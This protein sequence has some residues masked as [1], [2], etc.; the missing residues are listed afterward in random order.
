[1]RLKPMSKK[2]LRGD[3]YYTDLSPVI[4]C[5][6]NGI[7]PILIIQNNIGNTYSPTVV[8]AAITSKAVTK[9]KLPTHCFIIA[10]NGLET[11]SIVLLEQL[12]T[13]DKK[14]L[15]E[16][17]GTLDEQLMRGVNKALAISVGL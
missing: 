10:A 5:E 14:R 16:Y 12:R 4:G 8:V 13:I 17:I 7:R 15:K 6:Q 3:M 1:V 2:I 9:S 11:D